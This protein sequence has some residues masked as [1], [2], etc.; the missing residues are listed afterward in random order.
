MKKIIYSI[1]IVLGIS[2]LAVGVFSLNTS[3]RETEL[4]MEL[5]MDLDDKDYDDHTYRMRGLR[6]NRG[7]LLFI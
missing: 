6:G 4:F 3:A 5:A 2:L 7:P 1:M